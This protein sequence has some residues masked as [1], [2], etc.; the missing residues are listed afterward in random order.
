MVL[1]RIRAWLLPACLLRRAYEQARTIADPAFRMAAL[2]A[3]AEPLATAGYLRTAGDALALALQAGADLEDGGPF[4]ARLRQIAAFPRVECIPWR[5]WVAAVGRVGTPTEAGPLLARAGLRLALVPGWQGWAGRL[6]DLALAQ[7]ET[8]ARLHPEIAAQGFDR[9]W[10]L[11]LGLGSRLLGRPDPS[12]RV[13]TLGRFSGDDLVTAFEWLIPGAD[14]GFLDSLLDEFLGGGPGGQPHDVNRGIDVAARLSGSLPWRRQARAVW[15]AALQR[16]PS[17]EEKVLWLGCSGWVWWL[18]G[19]QAGARA[20]A[21]AIVPLLPKAKVAAA[22]GALLDLLLLLAATGNQKAARA[23]GVAQGWNAPAT[24]ASREGWDCFSWAAALSV[25]GLSEAG[26]LRDRVLAFARDRQKEG[27]SPVATGCLVLMET[28]V[29]G[30]GAVQ[31]PLGDHLEEVLAHADDQEE[32]LRGVGNTLREALA[33]VSPDAFRPLLE[34][35]LA[36]AAEHQAIV[37]RR[38]PGLDP[39]GTVLTHLLFESGTH[40]RLA[41]ALLAVLTPLVAGSEGFDL[42]W[43]ARGWAGRDELIGAVSAIDLMERGNRGP[44]SGMP[45]RCSRNAC[46]CGNGPSRRPCSTGCLPTTPADPCGC[47]PRPPPCGRPAAAPR[48]TRRWPGA[49]KPADPAPRWPPSKPWWLFSRL[50]ATRSPRRRRGPGDPFGVGEQPWRSWVATEPAPVVVPR[51]GCAWA[52]F[53][54]V[55][56]CAL[57]PACQES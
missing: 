48:Q 45:G 56:R 6:L 16:L 19:D 20:V 35:F 55:W 9:D 50:S 43:P 39:G 31:E 46:G 4:R 34:A 33:R 3:V 21:A 22:S 37:Q 17:P 32:F 54:V 38:F 47:S 15:L 11:A 1:A 53:V 2:Q 28:V 40:P 29:G 41:R 14:R 42:G 36:A 51:G 26:R 25:L 44:A 10:R 13:P 5:A 12:D 18:E 49:W 30:P 24:L 8:L 27:G 23:W 7:R 57:F 52:G